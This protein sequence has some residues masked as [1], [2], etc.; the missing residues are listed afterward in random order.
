MTKPPIMKMIMSAK[1]PNELDI[2]A[3]LPTEPRKRKSPRAIWDAQNN[4]NNWRK[5][6][7]SPEVISMH[8]DTYTPGFVSNSMY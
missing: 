1:V 4:S 7:H 6:L 8:Q 3:D 2:I 5:N